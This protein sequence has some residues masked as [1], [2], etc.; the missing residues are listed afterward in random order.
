MMK[1]KTPPP[2]PRPISDPTFPLLEVAGVWSLDDTFEAVGRLA[3]EAIAAED[4][5][6]Y[7]TGYV[8]GRVGGSVGDEGNEEYVEGYG[9]GLRV[10]RGAAPP[11]WDL[12]AVS[13]PAN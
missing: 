8:I 6:S 7:A 4:P 1:P 11:V 10:R 9:L 3:L 12:E 5:L 13:G 2:I